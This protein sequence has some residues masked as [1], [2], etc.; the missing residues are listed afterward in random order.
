MKRNKLIEEHYKLHYNVLVKRYR[1]RVPN[2]SVALAEEVVQEA[3]ARALK[4]FS[5]FEPK[6][7]TFEK[8]FNAILRNATNDCRTS[9]SG[10]GTTKE[11]DENTEDIRASK[12]DYKNLHSMLIEIYQIQKT[13]PRDYQVLSMF[14]VNGFTS[15]DISVYMGMSHSNVRQLIHK[16]KARI[17]NED[18][19]P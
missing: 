6:L 13:S 12:N 8:W 7:N 2:Q 3:Y 17:N 11:L 9:E 5:A 10:N 14:Y 16:F 18:T 15:K 1:R 19:I 4:Y